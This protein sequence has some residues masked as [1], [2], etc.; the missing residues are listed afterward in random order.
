MILIV[1]VTLWALL[2]SAAVADDVD[3]DGIADDV[4]NCPMDFNP[5][6]E[7]TD[8]DAVGDS[9]ETCCRYVGD[10]NHDGVDGE[11]GSGVPNITDLIYLV[12][13]M[14]QGGSSEAMCNDGTAETYDD[15]ILPETDFNCDGSVLP[16]ILDL[17][18]IVEYMFCGP[19]GPSPCW[20]GGTPACNRP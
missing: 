2:L 7:D 14:F 19:G 18:A 11:P 1:T 10:I 9:C 6:Q 15:M 4:D 3:G 12:S 13:F 8:G 17:I 5:D 16:N 20:D